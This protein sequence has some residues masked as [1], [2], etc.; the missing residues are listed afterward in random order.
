MSI[1][2]QARMFNGVHVEH[3]L[4]IHEGFTYHAAIVLAW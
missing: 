2:V 3:G 4:S 1:K